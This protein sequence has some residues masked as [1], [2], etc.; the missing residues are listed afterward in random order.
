[1]GLEMGF[2]MSVKMPDTSKSK[3]QTLQI[4]DYFIYP[5]YSML[6]SE[7]GEVVEMECMAIEVLNYMASRSGEVVSID[8]LMEYVWTGKVVTQS[9]VRRIIS[10]LRKALK[11]DVKSPNYIQN[12]PKRGYILVADVTYFDSPEKPVSINK[13]N[14]TTLNKVPPD[15]ATSNNSPRHFFRSKIGLIVASVGIAIV[16]LG[17]LATQRDIG[18]QSERDV[19]PVVSV[20]GAEKDLDYSAKINKLIYSHKKTGEENWQLFSFDARNKLSTQLT[21]GAS[22]NTRPQFSPQG[23][24]VAFLRKENGSFSI[25]VGNFTSDNEL[26][27]VNPV[28]TSAL[29]IGGIIWDEFGD[30]LFYVSADERFK[31]SVFRINLGDGEVTR[32]T[33]PSINSG[34]DYLVALSTD[35]KHLAVAR[36]AGNE[37]EIIGYRLEGF[38]PTFLRKVNAVVKSLD[39]HEDELLYLK[40][41]TVFS[42]SQKTDWEPRVFHEG[43]T[44]ISQLQTADGKVFAVQGDL[45]NSEIRQYN[46][47]FIPET[48][49][50]D[51]LTISSPQRDF[52]GV[53]SKTSDRIY[54]L[55]HRT[56]LRQIWQWDA[57]FGY[58]QLTDLNTYQQIDNLLASPQSESL[59]GTI[60]RRLF[61]MD[62]ESKSLVY[63]SPENHYVSAPIW[64]IDGQYIYYINQ[65]I[66]D[67]ELWRVDIESQVSERVDKNIRSIQPMVDSDKFIAHDNSSAF[68]YRVST[69]ERIPIEK[70]IE[71]TMNTSWQLVNSHLY[72]TK[73]SDR[74]TELMRLNINDS[75]ILAAPAPFTGF[76]HR[77][78]VREDE[79]S[80]L[81]NIASP[82][83]TDI[84]ELR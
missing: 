57:E 45:S 79:T 36:L 60:G 10:L 21:N 44:L 48:Q 66:G 4:G 67:H 43:Q 47:P 61:M 26:S 24:R 68:F 74:G 25:M 8:E 53:Y 55:S 7:S 22:N 58:Q 72:W 20:K 31:Y 50:T 62:V 63:L 52:S 35:K 12:I 64:S 77:F 29:P 19:L 15:L 11:D 73:S 1:M 18:W 84:I 42:I 80:I 56:G 46:N 81:F 6:Q 69:G 3:R 37:T 2:Q 51:E 76:N 75:S 32:L 34:G 5:E 71:L 17:Y 27:E 28:F 78:S 14:F 82:P 13:E 59:A 54:F 33:L 65:Y 49:I 41:N 9:T 23:D 83:Q 16:L 39:W 70:D 40:G 38:S 30:N